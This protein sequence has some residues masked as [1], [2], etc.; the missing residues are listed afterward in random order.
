MKR[1]LRPSLLRRTVLTL[2]AA[3]VLAWA[4]LSA[5]D[6]W[7]F[8]RDVRDSESLGKMAQTVLDSLQGF[9]ALQAFAA[10]RA[11]DRQYNELRLQAEPQAPGALL[12]QLS[13]ADGTLVY[14]SDRAGALPELQTG[15]GP[16]QVHHQG[17]S[18]WPVVRENTRWRLA[19]WVPVLPDAQA[20]TL[21]GKDILSYL[22]LALPFVVL[23]M[24]LAVW[25]GLRPLRVLARQIAQRPNDDLSPLQEPLAMS[26]WRRW[27]TLATP[28]WGGRGTSARL[29][30]PLC[31]TRR[32]NSRHPWRWWPRR[33]MCWPRRRA[34]NS[35]KWRCR[36]W[37]TGC[38]APRTKSTSC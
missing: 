24:A 31:R 10:M 32:T 5:K 3:L 23:P 33:R 28:C 26:S 9:D 19:I 8:K 14:R 2:L 15:A 38:S 18:Y 27:S 12:L 25:L 13:Q 1:W 29:N 4:V 22:L 17:Q 6:Y 21:I 35:A 16:E 34:M 7:A 37:K 30:R 20:L 36:R 11:A